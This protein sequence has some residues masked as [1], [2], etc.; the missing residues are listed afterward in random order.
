[1]ECNGRVICEF[2]QGFHYTSPLSDKKMLLFELYDVDENREHLHG[3]K[4]FLTGKRKHHSST[5]MRLEISI[6]SDNASLPTPN[7]STEDEN[8]MLVTYSKGLSGVALHQV[9]DTWKSTFH[10]SSNLARDYE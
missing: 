4:K 10:S 2:E 1:M 3:F 9:L 8:P 6:V 5:K 7:S